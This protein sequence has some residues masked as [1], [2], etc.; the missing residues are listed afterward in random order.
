[1]HF[2]FETFVLITMFHMNN[3]DADDMDEH[4]KYKKFW[5]LRSLEI[6]ERARSLFVDAPM[7]TVKRAMLISVCLH[8]VFNLHG[9]RNWTVSSFHQY[10][11]QMMVLPCVEEFSFEFGQLEWAAWFH[12]KGRMIPPGILRADE[13]TA[14]ERYHETWE[15]TSDSRPADF[16]GYDGEW[17]LEMVNYHIKW[18]EMLEA[19][20][21][22]GELQ[23]C[24]HF[25]FVK[26]DL[27]PRV[28]KPI[29][30][31]I[32]KLC[33]RDNFFALTIKNLYITYGQS[34]VT[35]THINMEEVCTDEL[36]A[37][38]IEYILA[39]MIQKT[40]DI[41][42]PDYMLVLETMTNLRDQVF[43]NLEGFPRDEFN[44]MRK[45]IAQVVQTHAVGVEELAVFALVH[46]PS[47]VTCRKIFQSI[48]ELSTQA[49]ENLKVFQPEAKVV[50]VEPMKCRGLI[51]KPAPSKL[52]RV[53]VEKAGPILT[54]VSRNSYETPDKGVPLTVWAIGGPP[55]IVTYTYSQ[56]SGGKAPQLEKAEV[57]EE[58]METCELMAEAYV[59]RC[60]AWDAAKLAAEK[61][62]EEEAIERLACDE[63]AINWHAISRD[64]AASA[65]ASAARM[66]ERAAQSAEAATL[67]AEAALWELEQAAAN[68]MG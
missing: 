11:S 2:H 19:L 50:R 48:D 62:E 26:T 61:V 59:S 39:R 9:V 40:S 20:M 23:K 65:S 16:D 28:L 32:V 56:G 29:H 44:D 47:L 58:Y 31:G 12:V 27:V 15:F 7:Q 55:K 60:D 21:C 13:Y 4:V 8:M 57:G 37:D 46:A 35:D 6:Y 53:V 5:V 36:E 41:R 14:P 45:K 3:G 66:A 25:L 52:T 1:M 22:F 18:L 30:R 17:M 64:A 43:A 63:D 33:S 42:G 68:V 38:D 54:R 67:A 10:L 49:L 34:D 24:K 51:K